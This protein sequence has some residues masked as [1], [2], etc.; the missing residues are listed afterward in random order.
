MDL[1]EALVADLNVALNESDPCGLT[2]DWGSGGGG[3][4]Q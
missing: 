2:V 3:P 4:D 1:T